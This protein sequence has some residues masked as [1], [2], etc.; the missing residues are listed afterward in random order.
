VSFFERPPPVPAE[1][2]PQELDQFDDTVSKYIGGVVPTE[3]LLAR[4]DSAAVVVRSIVAYPDGFEFSL[5][6][7][8]RRPAKQRR[9]R[10]GSPVQL[11]RYELDEDEPIPDDFLRFGIEFPDGARVS[12]LDRPAWELS[13]DA[14]E[15]LHGM[16]SGSGS[17]SDQEY[18][19]NWWAWPIPDEGLIA[20]VCE[21]PAYDIPE[22][23]IELEADLLRDAAGR[24]RPVW[25]EIAS[26]RTHMT[27]WEFT[28]AIRGRMTPTPDSPTDER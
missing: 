3:L 14:T 4:S 10:W 15:P 16:T 12:N 1:P 18:S 2:D 17:G 26:G 24:A 6:I 21:W 20:F 25:S 27:P 13:A 11:D 19:A 28:R 22:T 8:T 7:W 9:R 23:R 5:D